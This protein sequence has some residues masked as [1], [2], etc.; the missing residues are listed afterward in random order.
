MGSLPMS[1]TN[2]SLVSRLRVLQNPETDFWTR[3]HEFRVVE[4]I[5]NGRINY[6]S[7]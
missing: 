1:L 3:E 5:V 4:I 6:G 7:Q 2:C